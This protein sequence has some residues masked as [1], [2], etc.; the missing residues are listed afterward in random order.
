MTK[1]LIVVLGD[2]LTPQISSLRGADKERDVVLMCEVWEE[3]T[4]VR[5]HKKKIAFIFS[6]MR[7]FARELREEGWRV[8]YRTLQ[9]SGHSGSFTSEV[10]RAV[11][12]HEPVRI[13]VTTP[14]EWRVLQGMRGWPERFKI[15]VDIV[16]DDRFICPPAEFAKWADGRKQLRMQRH[17]PTH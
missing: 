5:H 3:A 1:R 17:V 12:R 2:Q 4:Y 7:H 9:E 6:C 10:R 13:V 11:E 14:G 15:P 16:D 8:D